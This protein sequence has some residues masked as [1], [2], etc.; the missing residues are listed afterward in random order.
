VITNRN[1]FAV[2]FAHDKGFNGKIFQCI[3]TALGTLGE[4]VKVSLYF[5][6][7]E[8]YKIPKEELSS[9]SSELIENLH[10]ILGTS[11]TSL[12]ER[13]IVRE[14]TKS[15]GLSEVTG[16]SIQGVVMKART[17]FMNEL[18]PPNRP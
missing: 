11:G 15:F 1:G 10:T 13:L 16:T 14:I 2:T 17:K 12:V 8:K 18:D 9:R 6:V 4:G 3:D 7:Q 5:Q